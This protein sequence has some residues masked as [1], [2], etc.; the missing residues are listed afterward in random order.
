MATVNVTSGHTEVHRALTRGGIA[1]ISNSVLTSVMGVIYWLA[2]AHLMGRADLGRGSSLLSA[3]WTVSALAQLNYARALPGLLPSAR[4]GA[5]RLLAR[6]YARVVILSIGLGLA[7]AV[8]APLVSSKFRYVT[9][10]PVFALVFVV[11]VPLYSIFCLEDSVLATI[12]RA[13]IIPFEN[14]AY[15]VLKLALLFVLALWHRMQ[16]SMVIVTSWAL[17]LVFIIVPI[18]VYLFRCG[19]PQA[20][21]SFPDEVAPQEGKWFRYDFIG[22]LFWLLGTL[23]LPVLAVIVLGPVSAAAFYVP[24]TIVMAIEVLSLNMGNQL[25]AELSRTQGKFDSATAL[26]VWRVW[27]AIA[28]LSAG[29]IVLAPQ[30]LDLFGA[31]YRNAGTTALRV[32]ALAVLPRSVMF[33]SIAAAR[34][35]GT[36]TNIRPGGPIILVLQA[37]TCIL[38]LV[39]SLLA[40]S[41]QG[42]LG[43]ALGWAIASTV[44]AVIAVMMVRPPAPPALGRLI[45]LARSRFVLSNCW[46]PRLRLLPARSRG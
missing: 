37:T 18:N 7:F 15:G 12:R 30:V 29:M 35:R 20:A 38:T 41:S 43:I 6:A 11:S 36:A 2:A 9:G 46:P 22:Y 24:F 17:P 31:Q 27:A 45:W 28:A 13:V 34:A 14:S 44:G 21:R 25:T 32:L 8:I 19:I 3:L 26:F 4:S 1:L 40:M 33:L 39:M 5:A 23:P 42:I 10:V 16:A